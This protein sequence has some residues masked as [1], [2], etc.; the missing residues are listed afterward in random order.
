MSK[1]FRFIV[2][3][4][5]FFGSTSLL[6]AKVGQPVA[7]SI[8]TALNQVPGCDSSCSYYAGEHSNIGLWNTLLTVL[9]V[10]FGTIWLYTSSK[11]KYVI[12]IGSIL[13]FAILATYLYPQIVREKNIPENCPVLVKTASGDRIGAT[14]PSTSLEGGFQRPDP[15]EFESASSNEFKSASPE[16]FQSS[17]TEEFQSA[18]TGEFREK[19]TNQI[20]TDSSENTRR[21]FT[22]YLKMPQVSEPMVIFLLIFLISQFIK[23]PWFRKTRSLF[24]LAALLYLGFY[25]GACPCMISSFEDVPLLILGVPVKPEALLWFLLLLPATY[26]FGKIWCGWLC[27][28]GA[29]Q[30][31][32]HQNRKWKILQSTRAQRVLKITQ[33]TVLILWIFQ[34]IITR[35]NLFCE[36]D[37]FKVAFNLMSA[38]VLGYILLGVLLISSI[39]I[40]RPFCRTTCPVGLILGWVSLLPGAKKLSMDSSC[41]QC[42][43]CDTVCR[44]RALIHENKT[45]TLRTEDCILCG[46][47]LS[48]CS[49]KYLNVSCRIKK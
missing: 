28:L 17:K 49:F 12:L 29:L 47:C 27:H 3:L 14:P 19:T 13:G 11:K 9:L 22:E 44:S 7:D 1:C 10:V 37:P 4:V 5:L 21:T 39:F 8:G 36:Y 26:L 35:T 15:N 33:I 24:L 41:I 32:L 16:E 31:F 30:E 42:K 40:Y 2:W 48:E 6:S 18:D 34:L 45:T 23:Y 25:R 38:N 20:Q 43:K 46:D